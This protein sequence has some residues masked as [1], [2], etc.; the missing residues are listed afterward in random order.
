MD[1]SI[2]AAPADEEEEDDYLSMTITEPTAPV[3][4]E[5]YT[6]RRI[7]KQREAE[8]KSCP[9]SKA[10]LAALEASKRNAALSTALP[11]DSKGAKMMAKLGFKP[12]SA[13]GAKENPNA[14]TEPLNISVKEDR[15]GI[16]L[17]NE[18][19][20]KF[21][22][23]VEGLEKKAKVEEGDFRVRV[24]REREEKRNEGQ[25][26]GAMRV[27]EGLE[28][29]EEAQEAAPTKTE[30][31][32]TKKQRVDVLYRPLVKE[33]VEKE[34]ERRARFDML[35][36][37]SRDRNY[38][39]PEE[40]EHDRQALG[41]EVEDGDEGEDEELEDYLA[42]EPKER[43]GKVVGELRRKWW[44]CFWCKS[45]YDTEEMEGCPGTEEDDHD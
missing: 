9:K 19:K 1:T 21:R 34:R 10:E 36:S 7:R 23:E 18:K 31:G 33:R 12:G 40:D 27:L 4:K 43:L 2:A 11:E 24:A 28:E 3:Q 38:E 41:R 45:K 30:L 42:L 32:K 39:D 15:G 26:W 16:G 37:L 5:T 22:E 8:E 25:W 14:R 44:Y 17:D 20:R 29:P 13:L 6:Q 35:Q